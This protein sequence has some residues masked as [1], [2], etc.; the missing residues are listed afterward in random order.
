MNIYQIHFIMNQ[1]LISAN[2]KS[3]LNII[4]FSFLNYK[5]LMISGE[6]TLI[7]RVASLISSCEKA[8]LLTDW[9]L[10][11]QTTHT[12]VQGACQA[13]G[14]LYQSLL[15]WLAFQWGEQKPECGLLHLWNRF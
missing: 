13:T 6:D 12:D 4:Y 2:N 8:F 5:N 3:S 9:N 10:H 14:P 11:F 1:Q 7:Q 15:S